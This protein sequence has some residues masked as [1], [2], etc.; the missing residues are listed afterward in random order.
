MVAAVMAIA[1]IKMVHLIVIN[2]AEAV[3]LTAQVQQAKLTVKFVVLPLYT[4]VGF[5]VQPSA[6]FWQTIASMPLKN[7][8][9]ADMEAAAFLLDFGGLFDCAFFF[10]IYQF[11][12]GYKKCT[13]AL[14]YFCKC[15]LICWAFLL[16]K[17]FSKEVFKFK[18]TTILGQAQK[19]R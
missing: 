18:Y 17:V 5:T 6:M 2:A 10:Y 3:I 1:K 12:F 14:H 11:L 9:L 16:S 4:G 13:L 7:A 15:L 19:P 8:E